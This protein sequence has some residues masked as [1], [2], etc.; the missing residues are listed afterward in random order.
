MKTPIHT[1]YT[2][3]AALRELR[4]I[5]RW[6]IAGSVLSTALLSEVAA[7]AFPGKTIK[8]SSS[9][10]QKRAGAHHRSHASVLRRLGRGCL[11]RAAPARPGTE[12]DP[13]TRHCTGSPATQESSAPGEAPPA[14]E[15]A[16]EPAP[17]T[18]PPPAQ[19]PAP[20]P[21]PAHESA[22][23]PA[24]AQEPAPVVSGGS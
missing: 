21:A 8:T 16:P 6:L 10:A 1:T 19:E 23:E 24:P 7:H 17:A 14:H 22:P 20:E 2:R 18:E 15:S 12:G 9:S 3:D 5:N 4:R 11:A 13:G